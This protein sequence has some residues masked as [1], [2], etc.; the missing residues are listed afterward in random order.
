MIVNKN[1]W[2]KDTHTPIHV[3]IYMCVCV[4]VCMRVF[5]YIYIYIERER[6]N[7]HEKGMHSTIHQ[8]AKDI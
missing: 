6:A 7:T 4:C 5:V 8:P 2:Y 3:Y 1:V